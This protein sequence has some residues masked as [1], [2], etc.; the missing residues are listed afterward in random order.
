MKIYTLHSVANN[1]LSLPVHQF[2]SFIKYIKKKY[3][4]ISPAEFFSGDWD[5]KC[6]MVTFDDCFSDNFSNAL[7]IL[8]DF[9]ILATFFCALDYRDKI[10]WGSSKEQ[11]WSESRAGTFNIPFSFMSD[12]ELNILRDFGHEIGCHTFSHRNLD[13]LTEDDLKIEVVDAKKELERLIA[14]PIRLFAYPRG[15]YDTNV[16]KVVKNAGFDF[17]FTTVSD[18]CT[19][20]DVNSCPH[21]LPR[22]PIAKR[23]F[24]GWY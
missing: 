8:A 22:L 20:Q 16:V 11:R 12:N 10:M 24:R 17:A 21:E 3:R 2:L 18:V 14:S 15:R 6:A 19:K 4:V 13:Q 1:G 23:R 5:D 7:P 9:E